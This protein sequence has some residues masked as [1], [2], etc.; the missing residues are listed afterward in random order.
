MHLV[1]KFSCAQV[2]ARAAV[3]EQERERVWLEKAREKGLWG[4]RER[5]GGREQG[6]QQRGGAE[7]GERGFEAYLS[8][9]SDVAASS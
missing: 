1:C 3:A 2:E 4:A 7:E 8:V 6:V 9:N 5:G